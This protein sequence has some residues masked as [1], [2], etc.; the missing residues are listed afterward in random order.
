M[1]KEYLKNRKIKKS[2]KSELGE[3][4]IRYMVKYLII[5]NN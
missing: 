5:N 1:I 3:I 2:E 4:Q